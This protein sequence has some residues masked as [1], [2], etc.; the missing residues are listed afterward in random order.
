MEQS[1]HGYETAGYQ[2]GN[3]TDAGA[4]NYNLYANSFIPSINQYYTDT[5]LPGH[6]T[7]QLYNL[8]M[9]GVGN[10]N[11]AAGTNPRASQA[12]N[13]LNRQNMPQ[14]VPIPGT[15]PA[16][17]GQ[18]G[19]S[20]SGAGQPRAAI[21][22]TDASMPTGSLRHPIQA[23]INPIASLQAG[24]PVAASPAAIQNIT[25]RSRPYGAGSADLGAQPGNGSTTP[26]SEYNPYSLTPAQQITL[27]QQV[28]DVTT[29]GN[30]A[31]ERYRQGE[32]QHGQNPDPLAESM[33]RERFSTQS[34]ALRG[35]FA[36]TARANRQ[37]ADEFMLQM[38][39]GLG[40]GGLNT[41]G[42]GTQGIQQ[43]AGGVAG[44]GQDLFQQGAAK[45]AEG[46]NNLFGTLNLLGLAIPGMPKLFP[47]LFKFPS[48]GGGGGGGGYGFQA[49]TP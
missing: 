42:Q 17:T 47:G 9:S 24:R 27:N 49:S 46:W 35:Q 12:A 19:G 45:S 6:I 30:A 8:P 5:G 20:G 36:E 3:L 33:I 34:Q 18:T 26:D 13:A 40:Q 28:G 4:S 37:H 39:Y 21:Q 41:Y 10:Q 25:N 7:G 11:T 48:G 2:H 1:Q 15:G 22:P 38:L 23:P 29:A 31:L 16:T 44:L 32:L 14:Y 43:V